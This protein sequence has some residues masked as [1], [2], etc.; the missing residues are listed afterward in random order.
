MLRT[1]P[2]RFP[3]FPRLR[4]P[5]LLRW[6]IG[7]PFLGLACSSVEYMFNE[8]RHALCR[9]TC[10]AS[11]P[12]TPAPGAI[13]QVKNQPAEQPSETLAVP[14]TSDAEGRDMPINL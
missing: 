9:P 2:R 13:T 14:T 11:R 3:I 5:S 4:G 12:A 7:L 10:V 1:C 8:P 6:T